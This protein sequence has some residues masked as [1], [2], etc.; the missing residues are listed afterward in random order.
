[1]HEE[2]RH[3]CLGPSFAYLI[4]MFFGAFLMTM[5]S[6]VETVGVS[7]RGLGG[8]WA[9]GSRRKDHVVNDSEHGAKVWKTRTSLGD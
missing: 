4:P 9:V 7:P 1:M 3:R 2:R 8:I 6:R 5:L